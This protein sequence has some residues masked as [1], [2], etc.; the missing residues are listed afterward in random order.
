MCLNVGIVM[1]LSGISE[2][3]C[4]ETDNDAD[5]LFKIHFFRCVSWHCQEYLPM[6]SEI[7]REVA[8]GNS[9]K[10]QK[11]TELTASACLSISP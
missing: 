8:H 7:Q 9:E 4:S 2:L 5:A 11:K 6:N 1:L 10:K 3:S